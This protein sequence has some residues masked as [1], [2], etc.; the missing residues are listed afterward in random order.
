[1]LPADSAQR[2]LNLQK[3]PQLSLKYYRGP[4]G[5]LHYWLADAKFCRC[6]FVGDETRYQDYRK[7]RLQQKLGEQQREAAESQLE[8]EQE[9]QIEMMNP[10]PMGV[11]PVFMM[12]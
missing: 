12:P 3:L 5:N 7:L 1:M 10:F 9:E 4:E 11:G 8:A 2:M 6:L